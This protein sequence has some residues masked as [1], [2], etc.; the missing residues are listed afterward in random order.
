[1]KKKEFP[2]PIIIFSN[3][4]I[5]K[6]VKEMLPSTPY[7]NPPFAFPAPKENRKCIST[8]AWTKKKIKNKI[9]F[10]VRVDGISVRADTTSVRADRKNY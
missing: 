5:G 10:H 3:V 2:N 6:L 9:K 7:I 8:S 4:G 1:M